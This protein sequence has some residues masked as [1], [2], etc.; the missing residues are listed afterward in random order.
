MTQP[1]A[2]PPTRTDSDGPSR[3]S[4]LTE[5]IT[6]R[7]Q[8]GEPFDADAYLALH[9]D[10]AD[11]LRELLPTLHDL[12]EFGKPLS[13]DRRNDDSTSSTRAIRKEP[14]GA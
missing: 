10:W 2:F 4:E 1:G 5:D 13:R 3:L 14:P 9:P 7:L 11:S 12:V 6:R 8:S